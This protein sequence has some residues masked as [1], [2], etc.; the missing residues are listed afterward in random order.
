MDKEL[1]AKE[2]RRL[3]NETDMSIDEINKE[4]LAWIE[5]QEQD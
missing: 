2:Y 5:E 4:L 1:V 3:V